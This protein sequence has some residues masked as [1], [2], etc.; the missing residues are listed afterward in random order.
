M[1]AEKEFDAL[2]ITKDE[3][4]NMS[5]YILESQEKLVA[6]MVKNKM[7]GSNGEARRLISQGGVRINN[8]KVEDMHAVLDRGKELVIKVGKRKFLRIK[9]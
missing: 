5:E 9:A 8:E 4:E 6:V 2:F 1:Q 3:P 7:V